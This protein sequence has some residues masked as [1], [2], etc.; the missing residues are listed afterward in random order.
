MGK[1]GK[2]IIHT[3]KGNTAKSRRSDEMHTRLKFRW[4]PRQI[5]R[6]IVALIFAE[7]HEEIKTERDHK[8]SS[9]MDQIE[10]L[11]EFM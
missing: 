9:R 8:E 5:P 7:L 3:G 6:A 11:R 2:D 4:L 1:R 10:R